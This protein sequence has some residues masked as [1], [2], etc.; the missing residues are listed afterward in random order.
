MP[1]FRRLLLLGLAVALLLRA[2]AEER[3]RNVWPFWVAQ[4]DVATDEVT[5]WHSM[6]PLVF[7]KPAPATDVDESKTISGVRPFWVAWRDGNGE[8]RNATV[9]YPLWF[10]R[11]DRDAYQWSIFNLINH[12]RYRAGVTPAGDK[13]R[14]NHFDLWPIY[15]SR[16]TGSPESS[17]HAVFPIYGRVPSR[18]FKDEV[19]WVLFPFYFHT[20]KK[21]TANTWTPWP[22]VRVTTGGEH[23]FALWPL[24]GFSTRPGESRQQYYLWPL[25]YNSHSKLSQPVPSVQQ[26][27]L[28]FYTRQTSAQVRSENFLWPF[29]GYTD[30]SAPYRYH[31]QRYF[32]P[33]LVQ[34]RGEDHYVNR[35]GPFYTHSNIKGFDKKW[36]LWPFVRHAEWQDGPLI[37]E[38]DQFLY[39]LYRAQKQRSATNPNLPIAAK[40]NFW[41]LLS[42]WSNGAGRRQVEF[43]SPLEV[44]FPDNERVRESWTPL[45]ALY[46]YDQRAPG[47]VR[48]EFLWGAITYRKTP[49]RREFHVGPLFST[50]KTPGHRRIAIGNGLVGLRRDEGRWRLFW[51]DF[52]SKQAKMNASPS[53]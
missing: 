33:F 26:G 39:F 4:A 52:P 46:R 9:L 10:Y 34:G 1:H 29:F 5:S 2:G 20:V 23:G 40:R 16:D 22:F 11:G 35:W 49:D 44:F 47:R 18:F 36:Y 17:Y 48:H 53:R 31:E 27:F 6:G 42:T 38:R 37:Q 12:S 41:P 43:P 15:F 19:E 13:I 32:W 25:I 7:K 30:R 24:F 3:E 28:P 45:F 21:D 50:E 8:I 14:D 51:F